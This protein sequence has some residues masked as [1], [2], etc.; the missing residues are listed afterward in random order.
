[1][2]GYYDDPRFGYAPGF[3][4]RPGYADPLSGG[5]WG[6]APRML[7][8]SIGGALQG[9]QRKPM[10][11]GRALMEPAP[12]DLFDP[13][14]KGAQRTAGGFSVGDALRG[15]MDLAGRIGNWIS[16][17][18]NGA[19]RLNSVT[20][21]VGAG[22]NIYGSMQDRKR[23]DQ[24]LQRMQEIEDEHRRNGKALAPGFAALLQKM[25]QVGGNR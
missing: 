8:P 2:A 14:G 16:D 11:F 13:P 25:R 20:N 6:G 12:F 19:E 5:G 10:G 23:Y 15:P 7:T 1:M 9:G 17:P 4:H 22:M 3:G 21:L 24:Q 18:E